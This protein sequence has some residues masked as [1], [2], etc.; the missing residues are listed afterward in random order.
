M[1]PGLVTTAFGGG[2]TFASGAL[3]DSACAAG[4]SPVA[5]L[6]GSRSP[7]AA[8]AASDTGNKRGIA[9]MSHLPRGEAPQFD[10]RI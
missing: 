4:A 9:D 5:M 8:V 1:P 3:H 7:T 6:I 10:A 2:G